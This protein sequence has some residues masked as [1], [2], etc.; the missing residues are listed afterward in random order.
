MVLRAALVLSMLIA[1]M[2][3]AVYPDSGR[4]GD[5]HV[6]CAM[7]ADPQHVHHDPAMNDMDTLPLPGDR[8]LD[9][10]CGDGCLVDLIVSNTARPIADKMT[11]AFSPWSASNLADLTDPNGLR[12]PPRA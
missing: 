4:A 9:N 8:F 3:F 1:S 10:C 7:M 12:R 2:T 6:A 11:R 5:Q